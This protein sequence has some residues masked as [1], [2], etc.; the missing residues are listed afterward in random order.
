MRVLRA[1]LHKLEPE[2]SKKAHNLLKRSQGFRAA[3][4]GRAR[5]K[6]SAKEGRPPRKLRSREAKSRG[7][8]GSCRR[9][10]TLRLSTLDCLTRIRQNKARMSMKTK[11]CAMGESRRASRRLGHMACGLPSGCRT[12]TL[13][14]SDRSLALPSTSSSERLP[15]PTPIGTPAGGG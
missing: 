2:R 14:L 6:K 8:A 5:D 12:A 15:P 9:F 11:G 10:A 7:Q 13:C 3:R 1:N 4:R